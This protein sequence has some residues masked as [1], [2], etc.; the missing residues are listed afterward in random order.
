MSANLFRF[1]LG[2][3]IGE[4]KNQKNVCL[5]RNSKIKTDYSDRGTHVV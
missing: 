4:V 3:K 1:L 2:E 5:R